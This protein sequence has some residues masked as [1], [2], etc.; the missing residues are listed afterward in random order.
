M[1]N[2]K[3]YK[4]RVE[5]YNKRPSGKQAVYPVYLYDTSTTVHVTHTS[6][7]YSVGYGG[8]LAIPDEKTQVLVFFN[9]S[10]SKFYY[11]TTIVDFPDNTKE[12]GPPNL[13]P[14][15][16]K[17]NLYIDDSSITHQV[18][19]CNELNSGLKINYAESPKKRINNVLLTTEAGKQ[20]ILDDSPQDMIMIKNEHGDNIRITSTEGENQESKQAILG[21]SKGD[22]SFTTQEGGV[23]LKAGG[24]ARDITLHNHAM[25]L[26]GFNPNCTYPYF[27]NGNINL[28][29]DYGDIN[30]SLPSILG[31]ICITTPFGRIVIDQ[32]GTVHIYSKSIHMKALTNLILEAPYVGINAGTF[33]VTSVNTRMT[34]TTGPTTIHSTLLNLNPIIPP[35]IVPAILPPAPAIVGT[36]GLPTLVTDNGH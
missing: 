30:L 6:P 3:I 29:S 8:M 7:M 20:I 21:E 1:L 35:P 24:K 33:Q 18:T 19:Y 9:E 5:K 15:L 11:L 36:D 16:D 14:E 28:I 22:I 2:N 27:L 4:G 32:L 34:S 31:K 17:K 13:T 23:E 26:P 10:E 12:L 25:P